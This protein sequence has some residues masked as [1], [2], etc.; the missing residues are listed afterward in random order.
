MIVVESCFGNTPTVAQAIAAGLARTLGQDAVTVVRSGEAPHE[1]PAGVDLLLVDAPTDDYSIPKEATRGQAVEK[2]ATGYDRVGIREWI[3]RVT[4]A[5]LRVVTFDTSIKTRFML[6]SA[7]KAAAKARKKRGFGKVE[8]GQSFYVAG[9]GGLLLDGE[10][11]RAEDGGVQ[12][13]GSFPR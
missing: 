12:L 3:E 4:R 11:Q 8:R 6:G 7:S 2:G 10:K 9:T 13:V 1:L 5:G